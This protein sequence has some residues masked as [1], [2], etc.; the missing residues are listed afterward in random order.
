MS[1]EPKSA[2][3]DLDLVRRF[4][5][6]LDLDDGSDA[7]ASDGALAAWLRERGLLPAGE[8]VRQDD[9]DRAAALREALRELLL[10]NNDGGPVD[11][12]APA[13]LDRVA[14]RAAL[15]LRV[16]PDGQTRLEPEGENVDAALGRLLITV[17]RAM[18]DGTW[19]RL[20]ACR[21][22][23]CRWAFYDHSKNRSGH[24]CTMAECG[25]RAKAREY[26]SR[27]RSSAPGSGT[28]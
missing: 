20:K 18:E 27:R 4:V 19:S 8:E 16:G 23:A 11:P 10:R 26:R 5:N 17:Y 21:N 12:Q 13:T 22:D 1:D 24:W 15:R 6:T 25:N 14:S 2:P 9:V 7:I 28:G 3:G